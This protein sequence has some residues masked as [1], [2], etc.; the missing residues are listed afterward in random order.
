MATTAHR[1]G[2]AWLRS[3]GRA[4]APP[5]RDRALR[6]VGVATTLCNVGMGGLIGT[7][8]PH[9]TR[10]LHAGG[11]GYAAAMTAYSVTLM[12]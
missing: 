3:Q 7:L 6:A 1:E 5:W 4:R 8:A 2:D 9:V 12:K 10:W 11:S